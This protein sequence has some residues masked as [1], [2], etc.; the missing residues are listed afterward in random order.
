MRCPKCKGQTVT[1][2]EGEGT[3][4]VIVRTK[5]CIDQDCAYTIT[6][7]ET[8]LDGMP[9]K[10]REVLSMVDLVESPRK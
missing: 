10:E 1:I 5:Q 9:E 6:T 7:V 8:S 3:I 4:E 2:A